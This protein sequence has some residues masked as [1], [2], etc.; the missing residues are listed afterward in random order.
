M[1]GDIAGKVIGGAAAD[2]AA[3]QAL[4]IGKKLLG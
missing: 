3:D 2:S 1:V 4:N